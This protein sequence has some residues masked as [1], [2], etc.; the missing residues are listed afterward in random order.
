MAE[1]YRVK[2]AQPRCVTGSVQRLRR[3]HDAG[4]SCPRATDRPA[5]P[6][7]WAVALA[8]AMT[9]AVAMGIG[10]FAFTP[11]LPLMM[12]DGQVDAAGGAALAAA[13]YLGYLVGALSAGG[14]ARR[15]LRLVRACLPLIA[16]LTAAAGL[17]HGLLVWGGLRFGAGVCSAWAL[18]GISS[19]S[20]SLLAQ[21]GQ[22]VLGG[23]IFTGVGA[24]IML[25]G[26][27][28]WAGAGLSAGALWL[29]LGGAALLLALAVG[30]LLP[31]GSKPGGSAAGAA[32]GASGAAPVPGASATSAGPPAAA[33]ALPPGSWPL[34]VCYGSFGFGYILPA[35]F[36]PA[37][38]RSLLDEPRSFGLVWPAF[39]LAAALSTVLSMRW[40]GGWRPL[41]AWSVCQFAMALGVALPLVS[42]SGWAIALAALLVGGTFMLAT[43]IAMQQAQALAPLQPARLLGR[44]T[45]AFAL[46]QI[47]G[48]LL[49][50][51]LDGVRLGGFSR[52][53]GFGG[54]GSLGGWGGIE[55]TSAAAAAWLLATAVWLWR[56]Q[57]FGVQRAGRPAGLVTKP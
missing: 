10:R 12:R 6:P 52:F 45:A 43:V 47:A 8:G 56:G 54:S 24:G 41:R 26:C 4:M 48:P 7:T 14:L 15:P 53:S 19:W 33:N 27:M 21:R 51:A 32:P 2:T 18:V 31:G 9:L 40:I 39:G 50:R 5:A 17:G 3:R 42:R 13:N 11:L 55:I 29:A 35:T 57:D 16:G 25:A 46:G 44:M 30:V 20:L 38:A 37:M 22:G 49:V 1:R 28:A 34:V 36:L 23:W